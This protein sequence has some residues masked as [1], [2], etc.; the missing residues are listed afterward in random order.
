MLTSLDDKRGRSYVVFG[1]ASRDL[2][3]TK[4]NGAA[5][6]ETGALT[7][8]FIEVSN[9]SSVAITGAT[10]TD[11]APIGVTNA[12]WTC[13]GFDGAVCAN[14]SGSGGINETVDLPPNSTLRYEL[15]A[16]VTAREPDS[17]SNTATISLAAGQTDFN[18]ANNSA[19]DTDSVGLFADG[20]EDET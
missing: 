12:S 14:L 13:A 15:T 7:S 16:T 5:F 11:P 20:F 6:V 8:W 9:L 1:R 2:A 10:L 17:V 19:T 3:I 4:T 18:P